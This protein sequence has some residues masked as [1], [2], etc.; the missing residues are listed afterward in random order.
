MSFKLVHSNSN[1]TFKLELNREVSSQEMSEICQ[2]ASSLVPSG[3]E[4]ATSSYPHPPMNPVMY[5]PHRPGHT[6]DESIAISQTKLGEKPVSEIKMGSYEEPP[7]GVR[8][9]MIHF[10]DVNRVKAIQAMKAATGITLVGCRDIIYGNFLCPLLTV[11]TAMTILEDFR[12]LNIFAK[13]VPGSE[14]DSA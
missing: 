5:G 4:R 14:Q 7:A 12:N 9:K 11:E 6:E 2:L 1:G 13:I 10:V 8:I 3:Y